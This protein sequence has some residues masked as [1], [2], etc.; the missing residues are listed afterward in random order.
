MDPR[1]IG[2]ALLF[3][4]IAILVVLLPPAIVLL[5]GSMAFITGTKN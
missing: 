1:K 2:K 3:P 5:V 4:H